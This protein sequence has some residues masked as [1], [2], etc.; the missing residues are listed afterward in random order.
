MLPTRAPQEHDGAHYF[1]TYDDQWTS[2][3]DYKRTTLDA[4]P[5]VP[6]RHELKEASIEVITK[7]L[8]KMALKHLEK[9]GRH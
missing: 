2:Q 9:K 4:S 6:R 1:V 3:S 5:K 8:R 7:W